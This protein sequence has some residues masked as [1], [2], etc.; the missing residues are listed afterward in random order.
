MLDSTRSRISSL[1]RPA[2]ADEAV[3]E[4]IEQFRMRRRLAEH[5][6]VIDR[7]DDAAAEQVMPDAIDDDTRR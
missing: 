6:E 7:R 2:V 4:V 1:D 3:G 5:A